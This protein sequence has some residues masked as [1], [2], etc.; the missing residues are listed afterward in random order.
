MRI[1]ENIQTALVSLVFGL[2]ATT[3]SAEVVVI[4]SKKNPETA[5][6]V[7]QAADIFLGKT[8]KF[9]GGAEAVPIDQAL[10]SASRDEFYS[11]VTGKSPSL[12]KA[13][14]SK[15]I[16]TG[17]GQ[18]PREVAGSTEIKKRVA[19]NPHFIGYIDKSAV[20]PSVKVVLTVR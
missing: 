7:E 9:P 12:M 16:F 19:E 11:K 14:W 13:H 6:R 4:V 15:L 18:P 2:V 5:L 8:G 20:D 3:A 1:K 10:G 17:R